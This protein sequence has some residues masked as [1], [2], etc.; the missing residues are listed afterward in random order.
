VPTAIIGL[1]VQS[2]GFSTLAKPSLVAMMFLVTGVILWVARGG[3]SARTAREMRPWDALLIG[4][5]QGVAVLPG[6][7][8]SGSTIAGG[9]LLGLNRELAARFSL[10]ISIP[11][12]VGATLLEVVKVFGQ[13][14]ESLGMYVLGMGVAALVGYWSIGVILRLVRHNHFYLFSYYLW[15]LGMSILLWGVFKS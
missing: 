5:I 12:I 2:I 14:H 15:P 8:R 10:L 13:A 9:I 6:I 1:G 7:S 3:A 11:A 4:L